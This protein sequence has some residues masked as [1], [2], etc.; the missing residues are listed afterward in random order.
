MAAMERI[1]CD[2]LNEVIFMLYLAFT[3][4]FFIYLSH[5]ICCLKLD[6]ITISTIQYLFPEI[7]T[8]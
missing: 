3:T 5:T 6:N 8:S 7:G 1:G 2:L 4:T